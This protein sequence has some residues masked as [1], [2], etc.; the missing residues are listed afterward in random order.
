MTAPTELR[1]VTSLITPLLL[2][3]LFHGVCVR[4]GWLRTLATPIDRG[5]TFRGRRLFGANKTYRGVVAVGLGTALGY[6]LRPYAGNGIDGALEPAW[7]GHP[8][9]APFAFGLLVGVAAMVAE[10]P[11]SFVK[12]QLGIGAGQAGGGMLG[13][14]FYV[15]DQIDMLAGVWLVLSFVIAVR[16]SAV[17]WS[18]AF[19]FVAHQV[20]TVLGYGLGMRSTWR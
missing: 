7:L 13:V 3:L 11:N 17:A 14:V 10:L 8:G 12:R 4:L 1:F 18:V 16:P 5:R 15:V 2:G 19:L 6:A 20:F 9:T